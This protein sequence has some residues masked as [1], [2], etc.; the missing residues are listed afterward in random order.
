LNPAN[1]PALPWLAGLSWVCQQH[2][3]GLKVHKK[4]R[5]FRA[6]AIQRKQAAERVGK[7]EKEEIEVVV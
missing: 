7:L 4:N 6:G 3:E 5:W 2:G 1:P